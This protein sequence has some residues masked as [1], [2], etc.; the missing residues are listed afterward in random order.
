MEYDEIPEDDSRSFDT[1]AGVIKQITVEVPESYEGDLSYLIREGVFAVG[2]EGVYESYDMEDFSGAIEIDGPGFQDYE[3]FT[4][5]D[6][7]RELEVEES[8]EYSFRFLEGS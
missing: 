2:G 7:K 8:G 1:G 6:V 4:G 5:E 3:V